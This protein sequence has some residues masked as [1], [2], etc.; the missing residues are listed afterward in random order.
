MNSICHKSLLIAALLAVVFPAAAQTSTNKAGGKTSAKVTTPPAYAPSVPKPTFTGI[1]YGP[2]ERNVL[3]FWQ[4]DSAKPA[5][6]AFVIHG[7]GWTSGEKER[8]DRFVDVNALLKAGISVVA[9]NYRYVSQARA[10]GI[11]P[12]V[13]AP[14]ED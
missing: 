7:G 2:H 10:A 5:P 13:K 4:A 3:D 6:L 12:P 11:Q 14:M 1:R 8:V 9:I